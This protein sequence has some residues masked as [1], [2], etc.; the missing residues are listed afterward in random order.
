MP[1]MTY[2]DPPWYI[3]HKSDI[4]ALLFLF[5]VVCIIAG[6]YFWESRHRR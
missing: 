1:P 4:D 3:T 6:S 2:V 5:A